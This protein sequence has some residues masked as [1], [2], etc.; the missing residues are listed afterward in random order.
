[1]KT[2]NNI[3]FSYHIL[4]KTWIYKRKMGKIWGQRG[5]TFVK[6]QIS[7]SFFV[8]SS[9]HINELTLQAL[10]I[11]IKL[12]ISSHIVQKMGEMGKMGVKIRN[13][14]KFRNIWRF[15]CLDRLYLSYMMSPGWTAPNIS[16]NTIILEEKYD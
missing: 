3:L 16:W 13:F 10:L 4:S 8:N 1:M 11:L 15:Y 5:W 14:K 7:P 12:H 6:Y 2:I 9:R